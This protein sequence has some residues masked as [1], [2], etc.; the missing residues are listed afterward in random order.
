MIEKYTPLI[1]ERKAK[2]PNTRASKPGA[3]TTRHRAQRKCSVPIQYQGSSVHDK[4][5]MNAGNSSPD[6]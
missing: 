3:S 1:R 6:A 5:V 2:N 4:K